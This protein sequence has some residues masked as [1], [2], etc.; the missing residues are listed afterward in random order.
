MRLSLSLCV[1]LSVSTIV[2]AD[3]KRQVV[4]DRLHHL[5]I[6]G[7]REW[8]E[9]AERPDAQHLEVKFAS[10][11]N[12]EAWTLQLR[13]QDVKQ[14]WS[15][16]LNGKSLGRLVRDENDM[17]VYYP[18]PAGTVLGGENILRIEQD[19]RRRKVADD[20]RAGSVILHQRSR[21]EVARLLE[22]Q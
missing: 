21:D 14:S 13:Q 12:D 16:K 10:K 1:V 22:S 3:E 7:P 11:T 19:V 6:E 2:H 18:V 20:I 15:V 8:T 5:R 9:F 4:S 17:V